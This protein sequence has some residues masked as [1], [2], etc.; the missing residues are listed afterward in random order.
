METGY[1]RGRGF[2][3]G[4]AERVLGGLALR[5]PLRVGA[6]RQGPPDAGIDDHHLDAG[7]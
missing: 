4:N 3:Q 5:A 2:A 6:P 7:G 1:I